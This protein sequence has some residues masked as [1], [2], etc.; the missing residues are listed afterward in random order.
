LVGAKECSLIGERTQ[1]GKYGGTRRYG[2]HGGLSRTQ[3]WTHRIFG[4][5]TTAAAALGQSD[6]NIDSDDF[7]LLR[8]LEHVDKTWHELDP[9]FVP[10]WP[11][12]SGDPPGRA[13]VNARKPCHAVDLLS[14]EAGILRS[15]ASAGHT[16]PLNG[17]DTP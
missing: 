7:R 1:L 12:K 13:A 11:H 3:Q 2:K 8:P 14:H 15:P 4:R 10:V 6:R 9:S 17:Q 16:K 5:A